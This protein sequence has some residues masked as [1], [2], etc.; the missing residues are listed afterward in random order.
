MPLY[1][2]SRSGYFIDFIIPEL[3]AEL[4]GAIFQL[5]EG[6]ALGAGPSRKSEEGGSDIEKGTQPILRDEHH[7]DIIT[8][9]R[10]H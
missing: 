5:F 10:A 4:Q 7:I 2:K 3:W 1:S 8:I 9:G 6:P